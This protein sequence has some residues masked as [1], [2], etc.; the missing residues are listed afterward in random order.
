MQKIL[1]NF[2]RLVKLRRSE[3]NKNVRRSEYYTE[4]R[5]KPFG[6]NRKV[7]GTPNRFV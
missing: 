5:R 3:Y 6:Y 2:S 1:N 4:R 7:Y